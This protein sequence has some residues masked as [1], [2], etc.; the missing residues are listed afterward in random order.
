MRAL[1]LLDGRI[2]TLDPRAPEAEALLAVDGTIQQTGTTRD[3]RDALAALRRSGPVEEL[4]LAGK[5]ALPGLTD[6]HIHFVNYGLNLERVELTAAP[7]LEVVTQRVGHAARE[8]PA[9]EWVRGWGWDHSL[10]PEPRFPDRHA[11][12]AVAPRIPVALRRKD[13][14][15]MW[16]N[17]AAL[18]AAGI[19]A[20]TPD[21]P[22][23][24]IG[25]DSHGEPDGLLFENAQDLAYRAMPEVTPAQAERAARRAQAELHRVGVTGIHVPEAAFA[26]RALQTLDR[27]GELALRA[28]M[29]LTHDGLAEAIETGLTSG[30]GGAFLRAGPVKLFVDGSLGSETAA[31]LSPFE[32]S[33]NTGM[34]IMSA[35]EIAA[36]VE[37]AARAGLACAIHAIGDRANRVV[38]DAFERTR[39]VWAPLDLRQRI[40]HV[41]VLHP[42]D[43][44]RLAR[45]GVI[46]SVQ[47]IH[48]TQDMDLVDKLWGARG[49]Y[50][51]AFKS[52]LDSG[53]HLAFGSDAPVE[54]PDPLAGLYAAVARR[55][56][57]GRPE[58]G[59][60]PQEC[61]DIAQAVKAYTVG[62]AY[63]AGAEAVSGR[64][65][66]GYWADV[67]I[68]TEDLITGPAEA[69]LRSRVAHTI[70]DG[71]IVY[72][73]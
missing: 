56:P 64:L 62:A 57:D 31:M 15:M 39:D 32:R 28:T 29:M 69:I 68:L 45:I 5:R 42:D 72:S 21:P 26:F 3:V 73:T 59:W 63:A 12:D 24:R 33:D 71:R 7:S 19:S 13:G 25:R 58:G 20:T 65:A 2:S 47:P 8:A 55:R 41:Q 16:L 49:R 37:R 53:A 48:A 67:T 66:P 23:G 40:E 38:L 6:S 46:A 36:S 43:V 44:P 51:Y 22:G 50:A 35:D 4:D 52:L 70:V 17:S 30:F 61:I 9:G 18:A 54:T 34:L 27:A 60:Y 11:L 10:W 14:H 1:A